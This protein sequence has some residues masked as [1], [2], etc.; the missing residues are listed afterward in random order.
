MKNNNLKSL[1]T[2]ID[3]QYGIR[4]SE[5]RESFERGFDNFKQDIL[6]PQYKVRSFPIMPK[7]AAMS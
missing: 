6:Q 5:P 1:D 4:G 3:E 2:F 7:V